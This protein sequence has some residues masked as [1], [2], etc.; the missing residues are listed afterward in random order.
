MIYYKKKKRE[1]ERR[2]RGRERAFLKRKGNFKHL[3]I[4]DTFKI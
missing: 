4:N 1:R 2:E 3:K